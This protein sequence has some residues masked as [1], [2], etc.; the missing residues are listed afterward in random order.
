MRKENG[1]FIKGFNG[2]KGF[3]HSEESKNKIR[4]T[5]KRKFKEGTFKPGTKGVLFKKGHPSYWTE[6]SKE[7]VREI[8]RKERGEKNRNWRGGI[9][10]FT[11]LI[12]KSYKSVEWRKKIFK[13]DRYTCVLCGVKNGLG[14]T[15]YFEADHYP[16]PFSIIMQE[17]RISSVD[18][19]L[20]CEEL[21]DINNGRTL[22]RPC[23]DKTKHGRPKRLQ[24][25][26]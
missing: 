16:K 19:G 3:R 2:L 6:S 1:Q 18:E 8:L 14:R 20:S 11:N 9:S 4:E 13:R 10:G 26:G 21:W 5:L 22:C 24:P 25:V 15:I 12:R 23:H 17:N 7:K